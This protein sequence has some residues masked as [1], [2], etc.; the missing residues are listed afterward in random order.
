MGNAIYSSLILALVKISHKKETAVRPRVGDRRKRSR[1]GE[2]T[3]PYPI[4]QESGR[5]PRRRQTHLVADQEREC[6]PRQAT[7]SQIFY[8]CFD[9]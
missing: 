2:E 7:E 8:L 5:N 6:A 1:D 3:S 9:L 4:D